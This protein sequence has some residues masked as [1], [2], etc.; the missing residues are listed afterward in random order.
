[1]TGGGVER[2]EAAEEAEVGDD[3]AEGGAGFGGA[4][5]VFRGFEAEEDVL[6]ELV[7]EGRRRRR[8]GRRHGHCVVGHWAERW[9]DNVW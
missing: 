2:S 8:W 5:E 9:A 1:M 4:G 3:A 6:E 7:G